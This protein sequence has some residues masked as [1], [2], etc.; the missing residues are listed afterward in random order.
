[1][2]N[3]VMVDVPLDSPALTMFHDVGIL[4]IG[5]PVPKHLKLFAEQAD[6]I[7]D[8]VRQLVDRGEMPIEQAHDFQQLIA[9]SCATVMCH[10]IVANNRYLERFSRGVTMAQARHE[11]QQFSVFGLQFDVAQAK[12]VANA[13]TLEAYHERLQV[14]LNEKGIPYQDGFE[15]DLTGHWSMATV[16]FTWMQNTARGLGLRFEDLGKIWIAQPGTRQFVDATFNIYAS[17]DQNRALGASFAIENWAANSLWT[18][19]IAGMKKLNATLSKPV[20]LG[21]L[22][23]HEKQEAHHSQATLEELFKN[24]QEPWFDR[25]GYLA[26][27]ESILTS[28]VQAYYESQ[29]G[30]LP[31]KDESWPEAATLPRRFDPRTLPR[32]AMPVHAS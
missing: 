14:L 1:M 4:P 8:K 29:L 2:D 6:Q 10:P 21:Y 31:G 7:L 22:T 18:P 19:W 25:D 12:L 11:I 23:Y 26:G 17:T 13:P 20:D 24:F 9:D 16:H 3:M 28:G 15:G 32:L 27:A 30:S 5:E